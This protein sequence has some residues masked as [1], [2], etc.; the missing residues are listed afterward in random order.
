MIDQGV[1]EIPKAKRISTSAFAVEKRAWKDVHYATFVLVD[2]ATGVRRTIEGSASFV[3]RRLE[4]DANA[5]IVVEFTS[6]S[7]KLMTTVRFV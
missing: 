4:L 6:R 1:F 2:K 5:S 7:K 3:R